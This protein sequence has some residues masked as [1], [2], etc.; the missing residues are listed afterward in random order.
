[1]MQKTPSEHFASGAVFD[2]IRQNHKQF[3]DIVNSNNALALESFFANAYIAFCNQ[4]QIVGLTVS[5]VD[6]RRNDTNPKMWNADIVMLSQ[7]EKIA[8]C[9]MPINNSVFTARIIGIVLSDVGDRYCYCMLNK[10]ENILSDVIQNKAMFGIEKIGAVK[11][12]G[13]ELM[14]SFVEC[15]RKS[16]FTILLK[17]W[18]C[19]KAMTDG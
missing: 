12:L 7:R 9:F 17:R 1:M 19:R 11:G 6:K 14:N 10:D 4:P 16:C 15:V 13:F 8:L 3:T 2:I 18:F 5:I